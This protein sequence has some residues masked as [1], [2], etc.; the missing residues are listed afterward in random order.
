VK[1]AESFAL[2]I[3]MATGRI[4]F[5]APCLAIKKKGGKHEVHQMQQ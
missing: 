5:C 4:N 2:N 3:C 1:P